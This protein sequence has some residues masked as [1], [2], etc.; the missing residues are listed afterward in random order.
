MRCKQSP[1]CLNY[2]K[3][4]LNRPRA[5]AALTMLN[6]TQL[7]KIGHMVSVLAQVT[8][9][10][11]KSISSQR[12]ISLMP[13]L[14]INPD[15]GWDSF[16]QNNQESPFQHTQDPD[17]RN[18]NKKK[19]LFSAKI[20]LLHHQCAKHI[21]WWE[22]VACGSSKGQGTS[23]VLRGGRVQRFERRQ[24]REISAISALKQGKLWIFFSET[25]RLTSLSHKQNTMNK[26]Q[27]LTKIIC[28]LEKQYSKDK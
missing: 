4:V 5:L 23:K 1:F 19:N 2:C 12:A 10:D 28:V 6:G 14:H 26:Y 27:N 20:F 3:N 11:L 15:L 21:N 7:K 17:S 9:I 24:N 13:N 25:L 16:R 8:A 22:I 18:E